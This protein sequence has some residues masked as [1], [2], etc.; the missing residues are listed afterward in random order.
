MGAVKRPATKAT[1]VRRPAGGRSAAVEKQSP[2]GRPV[3]RARK[4]AS[5]VSRSAEQAASRH[6]KV[7]VFGGLAAVLTITSA[8]LLVMQPAPLT[9]DSSRSLM[10]V[11]TPAQTAALFDTH[12]TV[13]PT[14]WRYIYVHHSGGNSGNV[15]TLADAAGPAT[16]VADHFVIG[17]GEGA[18][19]GE[20]QIGQ[21]WN[22]QQP[23]GRTEGLDR[24]D[25]DCISI[26]LIG[27]LDRT[28][29]TP[30]QMEQVGRLVKALQDRMQIGVDHVWVVDAPG[31]P[32]GCGRYFPREVFKG[33]LIP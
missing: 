5:P 12:V 17:N 4:A 22:N 13:E 33:N 27:D 26:C 11:D 16:G 32:A 14:R 7:L 21:R 3:R 29:P 15:S 25:P 30:R 18:G 24:V 8:L 2:E 9:P 28:L 20:I 23:A 1:G 19:D 10:A 6:R 31:L